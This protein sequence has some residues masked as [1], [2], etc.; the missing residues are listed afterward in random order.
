AGLEDVDEVRELPVAREDRQLTARDGGVRGERDGDDEHQRDHEDRRQDH[1]QAVGQ[2]TAAEGAEGARPRGTG[3]A[4]TG[5]RRGG[6]RGDGAHEL[7]S[8][9]SFLCES[10]R[11]LVWDRLAGWCR[12]FRA[13]A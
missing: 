5:G 4:V 13:L 6:G 2:R 3:G 7:I 11:W 1:Q 9:R 10:W 12:P 8:F